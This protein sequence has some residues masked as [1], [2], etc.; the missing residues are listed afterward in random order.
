MTLDKKKIIKYTLG[1]I[2]SLFILAVIVFGVFFTKEFLYPAYIAEKQIHEL[3]EEVSQLST[4]DFLDDP[5]VNIL[6]TKDNVC[7]WNTQYYGDRPIKI[8]KEESLLHPCIK[9]AGMPV[10]NVDRGSDFILVNRNPL[11]LT[12]KLYSGDKKVIKQH[13]FDKS[14]INLSKAYPFSKDDKKGYKY[15]GKVI[16]PAKYDDAEYFKKSFAAVRLNGKWG[17]INK[18]GEEVV[19]PKYDSVYSFQNGFAKVKLNRQWGFIN[20]QGQEIIPIKYESAYGF[21]EDGL[22][23]VE[24]NNKMGFINKKGEVVIPLKYD[25]ANDFSDERARVEIN[26]KWGFINRQGNIII[27]PRYERAYSFENGISF[28]KLQNKW[29]VIDIN[30]QFIIQPTYDKLSS[31]KGRYIKVKQNGKYGFIN[32]KGQE[33]IP[34]IYDRGDYQRIMFMSGEGFKMSLRTEGIFHFDNKGR[35]VSGNGIPLSKDE[36]KKHQKLQQRLL[37]S[38]ST[39]K[40]S[41]QSIMTRENIRQF[42]IKLLNSGC[43]YDTQEVSMYY[44]QHIKKF[45]GKYNPSHQ[46]IYNDNVQYCKR[47]TYRKYTLDSFSIKNTYKK[48]G[49]EYAEI[50]IKIGFKVANDKKKRSG[51]STQYLTLI[52]ENGRI[53]VISSST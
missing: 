36:V 2:A 31:T 9:E 4:E 12:I 51:T 24:I 26:N 29:G 39:T 47:W 32:D 17:F 21:Q 11:H 15:D 53:K 42:L 50:V 6:R 3:Y 22:A 5:Y 23:R 45:F 38:Q 25:I 19:P 20:E 18:Y 1:T 49:V 30:G 44:A 35:L 28:V 7:Y 46:F 37:N 10:K 41:H 40:P 34:P 43:F 16:I 8:S 48:N 33:L 27:P 52:N 13:T 14:Q